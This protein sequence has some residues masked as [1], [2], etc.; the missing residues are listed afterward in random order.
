MRRTAAVLLSYTLRYFGKNLLP[1]G[2]LVVAYSGTLEANYCGVMCSSLCM[3][4]G[5]VSS[6]V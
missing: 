5:G 4:C 6:Y 1:G 3:A 2:D